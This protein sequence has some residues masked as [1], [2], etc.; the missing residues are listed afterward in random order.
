LGGRDRDEDIT[1]REW[2]IIAA[3]GNNTVAFNQTIAGTFIDV[4][5]L[6]VETFGGIAQRETL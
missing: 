2:I 5:T 6:N 3:T 4:I 1:T